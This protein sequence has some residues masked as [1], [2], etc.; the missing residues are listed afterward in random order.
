MRIGAAIVDLNLAGSTG[1]PRRARVRELAQA[2][3]AER[4]RVL[5]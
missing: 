1:D 5:A 2:A 3:L 4:E